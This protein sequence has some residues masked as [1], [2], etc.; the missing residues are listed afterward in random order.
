M[1]RTLFQVWNCFYLRQ[2]DG[3]QIYGKATDQENILRAGVH[4]KMKMQV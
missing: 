2:F 4:G 1:L 3:T